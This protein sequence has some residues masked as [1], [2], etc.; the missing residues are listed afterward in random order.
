MNIFGRG[1]QVRINGKTYVGS[2]ISINGNQVYIDGEPQDGLDD[3]RK[4]EVTIVSNVEKVYSE[5]SI[6]IKGNVL[7]NV[8]AKVN[9]NCDSVNGNV[10]AGV[11]VN[12]DDIKGNATAGVTI[13]CDDIGGSAIANKINR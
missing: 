1:S 2:N 11:N 5:E 9:V 12:C 7:G 8:E 3:K 13:N 4:I 10:N 6:Y